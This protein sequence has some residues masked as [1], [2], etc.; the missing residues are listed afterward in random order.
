MNKPGFLFSIDVY[1]RQNG[2]VYIELQPQGFRAEIQE[3]L[4][5]IHAIGAMNMDLL[6]QVLEG[7]GAN[8]EQLPLDEE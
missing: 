7:A 8:V 4:F 3:M 5:A 2:E 6:R 1:R